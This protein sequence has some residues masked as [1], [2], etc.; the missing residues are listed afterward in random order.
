MADKRELVLMRGLAGSGKS[1]LA[2]ELLQAVPDGVILSTDDFF[3]LKNGR[4]AFDPS[5]LG[6]AHEWNQRRAEEHCCRHVPLVIIDNTNAEVWQMK[7]YVRIAVK[8]GYTVSLRQ[9]DTP[10]A[11]DAEE[12]ARRNKHGVPLQTIA[13]ML[14]RFEHN[15]TAESLLGLVAKTTR[16]LV[17][18]THSKQQPTAAAPRATTDEP[19]K[20]APPPQALASLKGFDNL[21]ESQR[22][23]FL[24]DWNAM[25][26]RQQQ[27]W[28]AYEAQGEDRHLSGVKSR[29]TT[30]YFKQHL[31]CLAAPTCLAQGK[32]C[33]KAASHDSSTAPLPSGSSDG[34]EIE[35]P[36]SG[37]SLDAAGELDSAHT[38]T[39][40]QEA[41]IDSPAPDDNDEASPVLDANSLAQAMARLETLI[42]QERASRDDSWVRSIQTILDDVEVDDLSASQ[43]E[44]F[45]HA[46][47]TLSDHFFSFEAADAEADEDE[48]QLANE[49][50]ADSEYAMLADM[51]PACPVYVLRD[52][53]RYSEDSEDACNTALA[54][55]AQAEAEGI[56]MEQ[57]WQQ[58]GHPA[59]GPETTT[60]AAA[61]HAAEPTTSS[62]R[63]KRKDGSRKQRLHQMFPNLSK[64]TIARIM[65]V[66]STFEEAQTLARYTHEGAL[67]QA[68]MGVPHVRL[69]RTGYRPVETVNAWGVEG[70]ANPSL[71]QI[72]AEELERKAQREAE[73]AQAGG[74]F[75][76]E[77]LQMERLRAVFPGVADDVLLEQLRLSVHN[78]TE[79]IETLSSQ[80]APRQSA[81]DAAGPTYALTSQYDSRTAQPSPLDRLMDVTAPRNR[82]RVEQL[83]DQ[84]RELIQRMS[85]AAR[86]SRPEELEVL[87]ERVRALDGEINSANEAAAR[88]ILASHNTGSNTNLV[89]DVHGLH[90][91]E[92]E[93]AVQMLLDHHRQQF[94]S[95]GTAYT[96]RSIDIITGVGRH[97]RHGKP[98]L[99]PAV[100]RLARRQNLTTS[101]PNEG[102]VRIYLANL[103]PSR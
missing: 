63:T 44:V 70:L 102:T 39:S 76:Q 88:G 48:D 68:G 7:P 40:V 74:N 14:E 71:Q 86:L 47:A 36:S 90:V 24:A 80:Y 52:V 29:Q 57:A 42:K 20:V 73:A 28:A 75:L 37:E 26:Q 13:A 27:Q 99:K 46:L 11:F 18:S 103:R 6:D 81:V 95:L 30:S 16:P 19:P 69:A 10:W 61:S 43:Q 21:P 62:P 98:L 33:A 22:Q 96:V 34:W 100:E 85:D 54:L 59:S 51:F 79:T 53:C 72:E 92:A 2:Q 23:A 45:D 56:S 84:R 60:S 32:P 66:S 93:H 82:D 41:P 35:P 101:Q 5:R 12:L 38:G 89:L 64:S 87:R 94:R 9:P 97:S 55:A 91:A 1:T 8:H 83:R 31:I 58:R 50:Q 15:V 78:V 25:E 3:T 17:K 65:A 4:Y 77:Q 67:A 49:V